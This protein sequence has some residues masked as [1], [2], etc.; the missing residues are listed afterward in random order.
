MQMLIDPAYNIANPAIAQ[1]LKALTTKGWQIGLHPSSASWE[2]AEIMIKEKKTVEAAL[3]R[4]VSA[5]RQ[6][7]LKFGWQK[8]WKTQQAAGLLSD[9]T[10]GFNDR[11][12]FRN[13]AALTFQP[14]DFE[15]AELMPVKATPL[16]LMDSHLYD[17]G[18]FSPA[19]RAAEIHRWIEEIQSVYGSTSVLW[20]PHTL[21]KDYGWRGGFE[22]LL[23]E[24]AQSPTP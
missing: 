17:Y 20:H 2:N 8:T 1:R 16:V 22:T 11:P 24:I 6:H 21:G 12:G 19:S 14:W 5:C 13:G 3:G 15:A 9:A 4:P 18:Q 7:W 10:L 23:A